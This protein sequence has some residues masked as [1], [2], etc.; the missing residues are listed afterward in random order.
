M[1]DRER[2]V[3]A[4]KLHRGEIV[5][6]DEWRPLADHV[7]E[8]AKH[9]LLEQPLPEKPETTGHPWY[10]I[11]DGYHEAIWR[12]Q[13]CL[14]IMRMNT[15]DKALWDEMQLHRKW[16]AWHAFTATCK[17]YISPKKYSLV[18]RRKITKK[19]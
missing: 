4:L 19:R 6:A 13:R 17:R 7:L 2:L 16:V 1:I 14:A 5:E 9:G 11:G 18:L 3:E 12:L 8:L 15:R 10:S